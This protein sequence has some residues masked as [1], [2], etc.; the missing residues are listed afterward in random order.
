VEQAKARILQFYKSLVRRI[1]VF[2]VFFE[3]RK[4]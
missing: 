1:F 3:W 2:L 4:K